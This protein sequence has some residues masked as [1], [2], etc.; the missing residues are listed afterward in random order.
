MPGEKAAIQK[1]LELREEFE[2]I[3]EQPD[4]LGLPST[5]IAQAIREERK[6]AGRPAGARNKRTVEFCNY[7]LSRYTSPLEVLAQIATAQ[8][9]ELS[10]SLDCTPLEALQ[11]KRIAAKELAPYLHSKAPV[12]IDLTNRRE[13]HLTIVDGL[14]PDDVD[15]DE[16]VGLV[17][18]I[19]DVTPKEDP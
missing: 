15:E 18:M 6:R 17:N 14:P 4:L 7:L 10:A 2:V 1:V 13:I 8:I 16:G 12:A 19:V 9:D 11:E 5:P 3:E